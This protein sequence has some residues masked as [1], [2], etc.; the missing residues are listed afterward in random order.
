MS[1]SHEHFPL[2]W[3]VLNLL[4]N[5]EDLPVLVCDPSP[6]P[7]PFPCSLPYFVALTARKIP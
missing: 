2:I 7:F 5:L 6:P 1:T 3:H 4:G